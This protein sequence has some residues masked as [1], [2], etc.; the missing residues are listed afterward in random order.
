MLSVGDINKTNISWCFGG[1]KLTEQE[2]KALI[3]WFGARKGKTLKLNDKGIDC[4]IES[5][6][7]RVGENIKT[8][9]RYGMGYEYNDCYCPSCNQFI[10]YEPER[11][12]YSKK[13]IY[14]FTC[15]QKINWQC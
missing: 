14:C 7:R 3:E 15:G 12:K 10:C 5:L 11:D 2:A 4:V 6:K 9:I 1:D 13:M 8:E